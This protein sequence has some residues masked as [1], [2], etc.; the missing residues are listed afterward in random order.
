MVVGA[1]PAAKLGV[2]LLKQIS[3]PIA[4]MLKIKAKD[5]LFFRQYVCMPPAQF[6]NWCEVKAKMWSLNLGKPV[7][8]PQLNETMAIELGANLLGETIIFTIGAG[9]LIFEY[10]RSSKK[11][12]LKEEN[13][14]VEQKMFE[15]TLNDMAFRLEWQDRQIREMQQVMAELESRSWLPKR[16]KIVEHAVK[17]T[18]TFLNVATLGESETK[19]SPCRDSDGSSNC[20]F[21]PQQGII[22]IALNDFFSNNTNFRTRESDGERVTLQEGLA[23]TALVHLER[24]PR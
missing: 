22:F 8:V 12:A 15:L 14:I 11:E 16:P 1:F 18:E 5:S 20:D 23:S 9:L 2:L 13:I 24:H 17:S 21:Y 4:N 10:V 3:K 7:H 6:Y 19:Y